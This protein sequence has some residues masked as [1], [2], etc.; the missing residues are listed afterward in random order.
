[1][2][3][4][5]NL[6]IL[7]NEGGLSAYLDQIKKFPNK[8]LINAPK[9]I[10]KKTLINHLLKS[11]GIRTSLIGNIGNS[12]FNSSIITLAPITSSLV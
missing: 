10:G 12:I 3:I 5:S 2:T 9:G 1:M 6:P 8:I 11:N 7:S 4:N